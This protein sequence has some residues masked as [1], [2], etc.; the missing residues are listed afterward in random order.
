MRAET[1]DP[2]LF[3]TALDD[4]ESWHGGSDLGGSVYK[5]RIARR[6]SGKSGGYR[7][8][9]LVRIKQRAVFVN[10]YTK[11]ELTNI[12]VKDFAAFRALVKILF[13]ANERE[14]AAALANRTIFELNSEFE[15]DDKKSTK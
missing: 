1:I 11:S 10:G 7:V 3:F 6:G 8:I 4:L 14:V 15:N 9:V 2:S 12:G 5:Q 13:D